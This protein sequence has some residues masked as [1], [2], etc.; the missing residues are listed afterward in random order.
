MSN[1][2]KKR[3]GQRIKLT[4]YDELCGIKEEKAAG[5]VLIDINQIDDFKNHPLRM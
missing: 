1:T 4:S 3:P 2:D 5:E